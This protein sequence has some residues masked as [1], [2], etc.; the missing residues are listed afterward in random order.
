MSTPFF[1]NVEKIAYKGPESRDPLAF[2]FYDPDRMVMGKRMED[3]LRVAVAYWHSFC[4]P[5]ADMFGAGTLDRP[6]QAADDLSHAEAKL[7][8]A[9]E[10]FEK[11]GA[12]FYC[13]HDVDAVPLGDTLA[14]GRRNLD[15]IAGLMEAEIART[16]VRLLWGTANLFSHPRYMAGAA[17]NPD[18]EVFAFAAGQ[19]R[20]I[21]ETTHRLN[22]ENYVLWG[23]REGYDTLLNTDMKREVDQFGRFLSMVV[24]HKHKIGFKGAI[25]IEPKPMEP[26]KHQY[27]HDSATVHAF[28]QKYDLMGEVKLNIE[29]NHATLAG[30]SYEHEIVYAIANDLMGSF[31]INRGDPQNGWDTDQFPNDP[32]EAALALYHILNAGGFTTGGF[33]F[34]AKIRR[35]SID[36]EDL[37]YAHIGGMDTLARGLLAAEKM[38][39]EGDLARFRDERYAG[40]DGPLG[41]DIMGGGKS[42]ADIA[43]HAEQENLRPT[44]KSGRQELLENIV[45]RYV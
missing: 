7:K 12:P 17:T 40:W 29:V 20:N 13:F 10:F 42:L 24:E 36:P 28:L 31:D 39:E 22:G 1:P 45:N 11:L 44:P 18:P 2:R 30:H 21:L 23:G 37:F 15:R 4:W 14:E 25:L 8:V 43:D 34:D 33:N 19:V 41:R 3:H 16:G 9:F 35:Q 5:G 26:T 32:A 6:W 27:D 38:I